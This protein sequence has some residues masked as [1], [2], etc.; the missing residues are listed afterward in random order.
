MCNRSRG[1]LLFLALLLLLP[2]SANA[3]TAVN[4]ELTRL[5]TDGFPRI[6]A[7]LDLHGEQ[8]QFIHGLEP[9]DVTIIE[10]DT[11]IPVE[12]LDEI[13]GGVRFVIALNPGPPFAVQNSQ[14]I[15]RLDQIVAALVGWVR[16]R[17]GTT[18]DDLSL[19]NADGTE[20]S[21]ASKPADLLP[22][23][24]QE[25]NARNAVP[26]LDVLSRAINLAVDPTPRPGM[27]RAILF[28]TPPLDPQVGPALDNLVVQANQAGVDIHVWMVSSPG[29]YSPQSANQL[30][31]LAEQTGG[32]F[33]NYT[34]DESLPALEEFLEPLRSIYTLSYLSQVRGSGSQQV[35]AQVNTSAG[36]VETPPESYEIDL[37]PPDPA[38]IAPPLEITRKPPEDDLDPTTDPPVEQ[39]LPQKQSLEVLVSFPDERM[40][41]LTRTSLFVNGVLEAENRQPPFDL[42]T[43]DLTDITASGPYALRVEAE[44]SFGLVGSSIENITQVNVELPAQ[45]PLAWLTQNLPVISGLVVLLAGAVLLMVLVIGGKIRPTIPS[46]GSAARRRKDPVT[47]PVPVAREPAPRQRSSWA[48]RLHWPQRHTAPHAYAFLSRI[49]ETDEQ[50]MNTPIPITSEEVTLGSDP[51]QSML[52]LNDPSVEPLHAR[53]THH[54]N[55][56][57]RLADQGSVAGTWVNYTPISQEGINLEHGDLV[58]VGRIGFRFTLRQPGQTRKPVVKPLQTDPERNP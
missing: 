48:D 20:I 14:A 3:Q 32:K 25:I 53:L 55:G 40:R 41:L 35:I 5:Q 44:D 16:S 22:L 21:H 49:S 50:T 54:E 34:G 31:A 42:F 12:A 28:I 26:S 30:Q 11:S 29:G 18:I 37:L 46:R 10:N 17:Q 1:W 15:S 45:P 58:H 39:Y 13:R 6:Q 4:A 24:L 56:G 27:G 2:L 47:Q 38:F 51:R 43:W 9:G 57:F 8:G 52:V 36:Q 7:L 23:M 33:F 19:V